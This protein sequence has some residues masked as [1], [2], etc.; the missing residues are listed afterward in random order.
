MEQAN[1]KILGGFQLNNSQ[2]LTLV[3]IKSDLAKLPRFKNR[4]YVC[5]CESAKQGMTF[6]HLWYEDNEL[7]YKDFPNS[8]EY[9]SYLE[10]KV[11]DNQKR[12]LYLCNTHHQAVTRLARFRKQFQL[13]LIM[14]ARMT[15]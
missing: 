2:K 10:S 6:H 8:L 9:Y 12:F 4:C 7:T 1:T 13:R 3:G 11:R 15:Q 14:A 5:H